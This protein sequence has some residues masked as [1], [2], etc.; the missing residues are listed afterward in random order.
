MTP[1][2]SPLRALFCPL[3]AASLLTACAP[4]TPPPHPERVAAQ[5]VAPIPPAFTVEGRFAA[6]HE[7]EGA[8]G[9]FLWNQERPGNE[10]W[11]LL[12]PTGQ[13]LAQLTVTAEAAT[14]TLPDRPPVAARDPEALLTQLLHVDLPRW[15]LWRSAL[16]GM[17]PDDSSP[18][19]PAHSADDERHAWGWSWRW[20][21]RDAQG[22]PQRITLTR[23]ATTLTVIID[24]R[25]PLA[26]PPTSKQTLRDGE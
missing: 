20:G 12:S 17:L 6:H 14:L 1:R 15:P 4:L 13:L 10:Q 21:E 7:E 25:T 22:W 23:G 8:A 16:W 3:L 5:P 11:R 9:R 18:L 19:A 24:R 26:P 2:R